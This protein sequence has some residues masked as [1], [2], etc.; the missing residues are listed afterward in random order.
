MNQNEIVEWAPFHVAPGVTEEKLLEASHHLQ[1]V[2]L[3]QQ[4]GFLRR[5]LLKGKDGSWVDVVYWADRAAA[6]G[7]M[8]AAAES[9]VCHSYF[10]LM[11]GADHANPGDSVL[12]F[13]RV[14]T[15]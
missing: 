7:A 4:S 6:E 1:E 2:F 14:K 13:S 9:P 11:S 5:D 8:K 12:H 3:A 15:Y 10:Q